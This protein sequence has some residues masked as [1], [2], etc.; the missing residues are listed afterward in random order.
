[1]YV[2]RQ[3]FLLAP[4][5]FG[6]VFQLPAQ[7]CGTVADAAAM[8]SLQSVPR[9]LPGARGGMESVPVQF[10]VV[11]SAS[12]QLAV[13]PDDIPAMLADANIYFLDAGI[14]FVDCGEVDIIRDDRFWNFENLQE[15]AMANTYDAPNVVNLYV[16][17]TVH[18]NGRFVG[19]YAKYPPG[20]ARIL[21][22]AYFD[23]E[24]LAHE[25]GHCFSLPNTHGPGIERGTEEL[26]DGSNC[27][28]TGDFICD[29][30]ADP[31]CLN[32]VNSQCQYTGGETDATGA[33]YNP[34]TRN[35]M[36]YSR[37]A[38]WTHFTP[39]QSARMHWSLFNQ[40]PYLLSDFA[41]HLPDLRWR[42][43][44]FAQEVISLGRNY[45]LQF[46]VFSKGCKG[47]EMPFDATIFLSSDG[48]VDSGD[49]I[50]NTV[51]VPPISAG[52]P[53]FSAN[54]LVTIPKELPDGRYQI[55]CVLD[56]E[57]EVPEYNEDNNLI[58]FPVTLHIQGKM[59]FNSFGIHPNPNSGH[60]A[61]NVRDG[62]RGAAQLRLFSAH[63][64][65]VHTWLASKLEDQ[66]HFPVELEGLSE[67]LYFLE[68]QLGESRFVHR[69]MV[70]AE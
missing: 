5:L 14:Q 66:A 70:A 68:Y 38:C 40:R 7:E 20:A 19:G 36:S 48:T 54:T 44:Q 3:V 32:R 60:F 8:E 50:L 59:R 24:I 49:F 27:E 62:E 63:G 2:F 35:V 30:P 31:N 25:L 34:P 21:L 43:V 46:Q 16:T 11:E 29:T 53:P 45:P 28:I 64:Q 12:G 23:A 13:D 51:K 69:M 6:F 47:P 41:D 37:I 9:G 4:L 58:H 52:S 17:K 33:P 56:P 65:L 61:I 42:N 57:N 55:L 67:G 1:M 18:L 39:E 22:A 10:H 26:V 15:S